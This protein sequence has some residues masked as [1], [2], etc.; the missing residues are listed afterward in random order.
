[1]KDM[2]TVG[3]SIGW[4]SSGSSTS[5]TQKVSATVPLVE[6]GNGDNVAGPAFLDRLALDAAK[7][8]DLG[9]PPLFQWLSRCGQSP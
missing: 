2:V 1:M 9:H 8:Q 7:G 6:A 3:G 4:A 5:G